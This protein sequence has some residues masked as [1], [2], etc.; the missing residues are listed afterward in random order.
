M[1][2]HLN[3]CH[4]VKEYFRY[5]V[6]CNLKVNWSCFTFDYLRPIPNINPNMPVNK[7]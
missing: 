7:C 3:S 5:T 6:N 1:K 4:K 2:K